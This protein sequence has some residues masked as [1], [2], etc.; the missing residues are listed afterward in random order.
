[1]KTAVLKEVKEADIRFKDRP[2]EHQRFKGELAKAFENTAVE[3]LIDKT[4]KAA[5]AYR[6]KTILLGGGVSANRHLRQSL[7]S[8][9]AKLKIKLLLPEMKLTGDNAAMIATATYFKIKNDDLSS[10]DI[11]AIDINKRV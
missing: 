8:V 5:L 11:P 1:M 7:E 2:D 10:W 3:H 4:T 9:T 6:P